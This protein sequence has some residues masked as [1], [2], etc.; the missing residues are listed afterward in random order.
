MKTQ[1]DG[2]KVSV[3]LELQLIIL[4]VKMAEASMP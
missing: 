2:E 3:E 4:R 1:G